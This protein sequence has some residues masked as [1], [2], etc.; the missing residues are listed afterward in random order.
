M[1]WKCATC[2]SNICNN[3]LFWLMSL[4]SGMDKFVRYYY[5]LDTGRK[6]QR[7]TNQACPV[8][9]TEGGRYRW[10]YTGADFSLVR[11]KRG[12]MKSSGNEDCLLLYLFQYLVQ[13]QK[14]S[15][16]LMSPMI[17]QCC[18]GARFQCRSSMG[19]W[20]IMK[21]GFQEKATTIQVRIIFFYHWFDG[22]V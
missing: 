15:P 5:F 11:L 10:P 20:Y 2:R 18:G 13:R 7:R 14:M 12:R 8:Y 19:S 1:L 6:N 16:F 21:S 9:S 4:I 17:R 22:S 3:A